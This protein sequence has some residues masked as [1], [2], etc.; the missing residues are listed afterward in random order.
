VIYTLS[1]IDLVLAGALAPA[2]KADMH[3]TDAQLGFA[4][5]TAF[6]I[7]FAGFSIPLGWLADRNSRKWIITTSLFLWSAFTALFG[8]A[9]TFTGLVVTRSGVG[10]G[11]AGGGAPMHSLL[12][13]YFPKNQRARVMAIYGFGVP[14]GIALGAALGG[15]ASALYGWRTTFFIAG[16][17]GLVLSV[18]FN[19]SVREPRRI[20]EDG[21]PPNPASLIRSVK[22]MASKPAFIA[23]CG[24]VT[25]GGI[26]GASKYFWITSYLTRSFEL[27]LVEVTTAFGIINFAAGIAGAWVGGY[28]SDRLAIKHGPAAHAWVMSISFIVTIP[29][30]CGILLAGSPVVA[31]AFLAAETF[32][33]SFENGPNVAAVQHLATASLRGTAASMFNVCLITISM[34]VGV[35]LVGALSDALMARYGTESLRYALLS[36]P[37]FYGIGAAFYARAGKCM[38][39]EKIIA[40]PMA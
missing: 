21:L 12:M 24:G 31:F 30:M 22:T 18:I 2:I 29:M 32:F 38:R 33:V 3:L 40:V 5:S 36:L 37:L 13:D 4:S 9:L 39:D 23:L 15:W 28:I 27:S 17:V 35:P 1:R 19:L 16:G 20:T 6:A 10:L 8:T 34:G 11:E 7:F 25:S 26:A 14:V